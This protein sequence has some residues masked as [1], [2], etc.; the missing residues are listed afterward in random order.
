MESF[1]TRM[2]VEIEVETQFGPASA[3]DVLANLL[4]VPAVKG[5]VLQR[6]ESDYVIHPS[7]T[8]DIN[9]IVL[10]RMLPVRLK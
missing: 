2:T 7:F 4:Q 10:N 8:Q 6:L 3:I 5:I 9:T 1:K